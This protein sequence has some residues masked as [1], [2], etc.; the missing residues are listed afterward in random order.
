M[1][2]LLRS[3]FAFVGRGGGDGGASGGASGGAGGGGAEMGS[4]VGAEMGSRV[5]RR[6]ARLLPGLPGLAI[7]EGQWTIEHWAILSIL[8][9]LLLATAL[10]LLYARRRCPASCCRCLRGAV[11]G[12][13]KRALGTALSKRAVV[14]HDVRQIVADDVVLRGRL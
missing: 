13:H 12:A 2:S 1:G 9:N 3:A 10:V 11:P 5:G 7:A 4:R 8:T 14:V 6:Q